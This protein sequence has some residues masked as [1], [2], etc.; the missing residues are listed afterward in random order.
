MSKALN[1]LQSNKTLAQ[2]ASEVIERIKKDTELTY[3]DTLQ[4]KR[5]NLSDQI[6]DLSNFSLETNLNRGQMAL[7]I[8]ESKARF[9]TIMELEYELKLTEQELKVKTGIFNDYFNAA[10]VKEAE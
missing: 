1:L 6:A 8:E 4:R 3:V 2:R 5:D 7:S 10:L 9:T